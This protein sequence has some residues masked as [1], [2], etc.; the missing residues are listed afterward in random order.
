MDF[1]LNIN[2]TRDHFR[3][4]EKL[5]DVDFLMKYSDKSR[6]ICALV[7]IRFNFNFVDSLIYLNS[8]E[9]ATK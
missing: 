9:C 3:K 2:N 5:S 7:L 8:S 4:T 6:E 1:D